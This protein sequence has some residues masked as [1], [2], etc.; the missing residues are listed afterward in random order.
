[1]RIFRFLALL[2]L[3]LALFLG[4]CASVS[5]TVG[6]GSGSPLERLEGGGR[7]YFFADP[8]KIRPLV[9][10][11][12]SENVS[13][14]KDLRS[15]DFQALINR[16]SSVVGAL[17]PKQTDRSYLILAQG[18]YP[19][20]RMN[21]SLCWDRNWKSK[22]SVS[23]LSYWRSEDKK[24][25]LYLSPRWV[26]LSDGDPIIQGS[27]NHIPDGFDRMSRGALL[28]AWSDDSSQWNRFLSF[29][30]IRIPIDRLLFA[31]YSTADGKG[32]TVVL[33]L[34]TPSVS[35]AR[36]V[37]ALL[38][39]GRRVML[40]QGDGENPW[41]AILFTNPPVVENTDVV[42]SSSPLKDGDL[43]LLFKSLLVYLDH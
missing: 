41:L 28:A 18:D 42:I 2:P 4:S 22:K 13:L 6:P 29:A 10:A 5:E 43:A 3:P 35:Q 25:S 30:P 21:F 24:V 14:T 33:R 37:G 31:L 39:I 36:S 20:L 40:N 26:S 19:S 17:Y 16:T 9:S 15:S 7:V 8:H 34:Q 11:V 32:T 23:G 38:S 12:L 27:G 1:M